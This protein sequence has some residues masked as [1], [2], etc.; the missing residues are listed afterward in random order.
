MRLFS[1]A[2]RE[3]SISLCRNVGNPS[4]EARSDSLDWGQDD[5]DLDLDDMRLAPKKICI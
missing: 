1:R 3:T 2:V 5:L 4:D